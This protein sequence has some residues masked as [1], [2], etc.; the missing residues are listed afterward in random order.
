[1]LMKDVSPCT[2]PTT[3]IDHDLETFVYGA[4]LN[5]GEYWKLPLLAHFVARVRRFALTTLVAESAPGLRQREAE[6]PYI[7]DGDSSGLFRQLTIL[8][9]AA[10]ATRAHNLL[11]NAVIF[12]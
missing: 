8:G 3:T 11:R 4:L 9:A 10:C 12:V 1:M 6:S 7:D 5:V 2:G